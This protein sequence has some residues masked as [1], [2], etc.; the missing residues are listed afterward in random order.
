LALFPYVKS[1]SLTV[2]PLLAKRISKK[3][4]RGTFYTKKTKVTKNLVSGIE[5]RD[6]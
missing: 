1:S 2:F 3:K 6:G 4:M 5:D